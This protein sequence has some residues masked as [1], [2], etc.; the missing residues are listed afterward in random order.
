M[1]NITVS[2]PSELRRII[3]LFNKFAVEYLLFKCEH[4]LEGRNKNLDVLLKTIN[5]YTKASCLLEEQGYV[6]YIDEKI[7]KYKK[8]YV[9]FDGKILSAVHLHREVAWHGNI[10][11]DKGKMFE[12]AQEN[13]PSPE[14]S[15]LIHSAH[16]LF[17]NFKVEEYHRQLLEKY[18]SEVKDPDYIDS[19]LY[20]YGWK[21]AFDNFMSDLSVTSPLILQAYISCLW[22]RPANAPYLFFKIIAAGRRR[23]NPNKKGYLISLIGINGSGKST[24]KEALLAAYKP[25]TGF[26]AGQYGYYYGWKQSIAGKALSFFSVKRGVVKIFDQASEEKVKNFDLFQELLFLYIYFQFMF[27]YVKDVYPRMRENKLVVTD[28]YFY[29]LYGQY[30]YSQKSRIIHF[31][32]IP[33]PD[34]L[35]VLD[36]GTDIVMKRDKWGKAARQVHPQEKLEGQRKRYFLVGKRNGALILD[37]EGK[38][39]ENIFTIINNTWRKYIRGK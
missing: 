14:D 23:I 33:K 13:L 12:R 27:R 28:R 24:T 9:F 36:A 29:D 16:A 10:V 32:P 5:D 4:V 1:I 38:F 31:L 30:P 11:L 21:K 3:E 22:K 19:Q 26:V 17:E 8:M 25:L 18:K 37:A 39:D 35:V 15:L 6:L 2:M 34:Q 7:E 20:Q